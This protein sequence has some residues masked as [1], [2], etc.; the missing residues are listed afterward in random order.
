MAT[1]HIVESNGVQPIDGVAGAPQAIKM[2]PV[3]TQ[4]V[5]FTSGNQA[6][7]AFND[8]TVLVQLESDTDCRL[9]WG[10]GTPVANASS[11]QVLKANRM[12][13]YA[14]PKGGGLKVAAIT[15]A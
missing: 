2:P 5:E 14:V 1:L 10:T 11:G 7:S 4:D 15:K 8:S 9:A 13:V 3:A 6:S 12:V